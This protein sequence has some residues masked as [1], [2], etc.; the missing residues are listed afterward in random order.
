MNLYPDA[1][2][3]GGRYIIFPIERDTIDEGDVRVDYTAS[4]KDQIFVRYSRA[5]RTDIRPAPLPGLANGGDS[6]TG[7]GYEDTD[8]ASLGYTRTLTSKAV[9]EFRVGFN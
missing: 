7:I 6:S 3:P 9:N 1:N 8:G 2:S 4:E 5:G